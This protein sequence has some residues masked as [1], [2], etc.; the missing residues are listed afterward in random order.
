MEIYKELKTTESLEFEKLLNTH[1]SKNQKIE[2][3][4]IYEAE[5]VKVSDKF[6]FCYINGIKSEPILDINNL[7]SM[8]MI[9]KA[10]VGEKILRSL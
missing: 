10:K 1:L 6:V 3:G 7:K 8:G 4:K 9:D 5:V 2:E